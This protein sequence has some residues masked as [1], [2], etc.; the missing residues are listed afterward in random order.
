MDSQRAEH[1]LSPAT[2]STDAD[3]AK[4]K[5]YLYNNFPDAW[6]RQKQLHEL[7][8]NSPNVKSFDPPS[9]MPRVAS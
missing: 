5:S 7:Q 4:E 3:A 9:S 6:A 2:Q 8:K 1:T